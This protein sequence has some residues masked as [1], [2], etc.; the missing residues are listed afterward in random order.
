MF[1]INSNEMNNLHSLLITTVVAQYTLAA[2][3]SIIFCKNTLEM[4]NFLVLTAA[5]VAAGLV[6]IIIN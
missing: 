5:F 3:L 1:F 6:R 4:S 2:M